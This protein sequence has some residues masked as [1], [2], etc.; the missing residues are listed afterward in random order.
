MN[1][2]TLENPLQVSKINSS[3][4]TSIESSCL[5]IL[6]MLEKTKHSDTAYP[7]SICRFIDKEAERLKKIDNT[8]SDLIIN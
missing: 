5:H 1:S 8:L 2:S 4:V 6:D 3:V 7:E